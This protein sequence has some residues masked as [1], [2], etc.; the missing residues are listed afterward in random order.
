[1]SVKVSGVQYILDALQV[2]FDGVVAAAGGDFTTIQAADDDLD[3]ADFS[4]LVRPGTYAGWTTS[5]DD[6]Y[7]VLGPGVTITSTIV[8]T[9]ANI[10]LVIGPG[11][12]IQG[13]L[14][15]T[16]VGCH[17]VCQNACDLNEVLMDGN[18]GYL[19]GGG[20]DTLVLGSDG[21]IGVRVTG[22]DCIV[23]NIAVQT[24]TGGAGSDA[25]SL[26]AARFVVRKVKVVDSDLIGINVAVGGVDG[27]VEGCNVLG[28]DGDGIRNTGPRNRFVGNFVSQAVG[29]NAMT[30]QGT[31]DDSAIVGNI[32]QAAL[33]LDANGDDLVVTGNRIDTTLTDNSTGSTVADNRLDAF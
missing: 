32:F 21:V 6:A 29:A 10:T 3:A 14:D 4:L 13:R 7:I 33:V 5:T 19:S 9:G 17:V 23:E 24:T 25:I 15:L 8:L 22:T 31:G 26:E 16:G 20:L 2:N 18:F 27:L 11:A 28:A 1:M 30:N 12:D